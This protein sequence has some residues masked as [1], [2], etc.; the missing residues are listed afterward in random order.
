VKQLPLALLPLSALLFTVVGCGSS[1][2]PPPFALSC[3]THLL[4]SGAVRAAVTVKSNSSKPGS[5]ILYGPA[6]RLVTHEYPLLSTR[7]VID[8]SGGGQ[9][10]YI[11]FIVP[12]IKANGSAHL[13]LRFTRPAQPRAVF[14]TDQPHVTG[15]S[16]QTRDCVIKGR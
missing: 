13:L 5:A 1:A 12:R 16:S 8:R 10:T 2:P 15:A 6:L 14:V 11:G 3:K 4:P 7:F 9:T